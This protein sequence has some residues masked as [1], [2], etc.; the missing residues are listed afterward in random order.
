MGKRTPDAII[1]LQ[2]DQVEG[3]TIHVCSAEPA[4]YA[5]IAAVELASG[6]ISGSYTKADGDTSGRK[7]TCPAQTGLNIGTS[8]DADH[9]VVSN[10]VDTIKDITTCPT[11]SLTSGGTVDVNAFDHEIGDVS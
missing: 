5:G 1:D 8:G 2:L 11:Q 7:T 10:G 9:I 3:S 4:N 6:T